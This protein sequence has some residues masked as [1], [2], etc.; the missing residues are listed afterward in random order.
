MNDLSDIAYDEMR[1]EELDQAQ[2]AFE[3]WATR[4]EKH[5]TLNR[6]EC[7]RGWHAGVE[8]QERLQRM[9]IAQMASDLNHLQSENQRLWKLLQGSHA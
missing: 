2:Q 7:A 1:Q 6:S 8:Y 9:E 5:D 3:K 4:I